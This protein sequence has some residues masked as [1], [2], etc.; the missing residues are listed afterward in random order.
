MII[1][2][3]YYYDYSICHPSFSSAMMSIKQPYN[4]NRAV[5]NLFIYLFIIIYSLFIYSFS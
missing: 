2:I 5:D 3:H 1:S 4:I